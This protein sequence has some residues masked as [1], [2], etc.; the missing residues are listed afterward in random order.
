M[1]ELQ[2]VYVQLWKIWFAMEM[3]LH[4]MDIQE[5]EYCLVKHVS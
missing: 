4:L 3:P 5:Y 1:D 2:Y